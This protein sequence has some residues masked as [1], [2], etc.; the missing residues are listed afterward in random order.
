MAPEALDE[1]GVNALAARM[2]ALAAYLAIDHC[3]SAVMR[4]KDAAVAS[5]SESLDHVLDALNAFDTTLQA[6]ESFRSLPATSIA[7]AHWR[8]LLAA[9]H[10]EIPPWWLDDT[11]DQRHRSHFD[12]VRPRSMIRLRIT[13][14]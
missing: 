1:F 12:L 8:K 11:L 10:R 14:P 9:P 5:L 4:Q 7:A 13:R 6:S 2:E 3:Y